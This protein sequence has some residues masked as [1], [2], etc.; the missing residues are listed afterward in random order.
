MHRHYFCH[1]GAWLIRGM[2]R[3]K[4]ARAGVIS[5]GSFPAHPGG[6]RDEGE[7]GTL[8]EYDWMGE[9]VDDV[10]RRSP[11]EGLEDYQGILNNII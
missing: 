3:N 9:A 8:E 5:F 7:D 2:D 4:Q 10:Q 1:S 6:P 11:D